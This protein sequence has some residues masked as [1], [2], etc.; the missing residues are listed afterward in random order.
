MAE[1]REDDWPPHLRGILVRERERVVD[2]FRHWE[3][4]GEGG[5]VSAEHFKAGLYVLG[6]RVSRGDVDDLYAAMGVEQGGMLRFAELRRQLAALAFNQTAA[7]AAGAAVADA[8]YEGRNWRYVPAYA[9]QA[10]ARARFPETPWAP[11]FEH[12]RID[13]G[14]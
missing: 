11:V 4:V 9:L 14:L 7:A 10:L 12:R 1:I 6:H 3:G 8:Y 2:L 5:R 13:E